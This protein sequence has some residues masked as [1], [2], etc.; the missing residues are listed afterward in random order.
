[1]ARLLFEVSFSRPLLN[2]NTV[3]NRATR[4]L[5]GMIVI[6]FSPMRELLIQVSAGLTLLLDI[7]IERILADRQAKF[8]EEAPT[9]DLR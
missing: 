7:A 5:V 6:L 8:Q 2:A 3:G 9:D 1:M 4:G